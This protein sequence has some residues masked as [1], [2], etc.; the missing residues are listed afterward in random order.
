MYVNWVCKHYYIN[1]NVFALA[2]MYAIVKVKRGQTLI[3]TTIS[4]CVIVDLGTFHLIQNQFA[5]FS[6]E[7]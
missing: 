5:I 2:R 6:A 7:I 1:A 3:N 4:A